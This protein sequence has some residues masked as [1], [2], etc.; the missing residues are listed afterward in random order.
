VSFETDDEIVKAALAAD[1]ALRDAL[2]A[3][4][5]DAVDRLYAPEFTLNGPAMRVQT[6]KETLELLANKAVSQVGVQR[7]IEAAYRSGTDVVVIMGYE[8]F[9]WQGTGSDLDGR[10]TARR[11]TN[12]W[13]LV[14]GE[15][16]DIARQATTVPV[17]EQ[18]A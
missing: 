5:V 8:S 3:H 17:R 12:I 4:D 16:Q 11:F 9:T 10:L 15:W 7:S 2:H 14:D 1:Q 18:S 13:R 6:R